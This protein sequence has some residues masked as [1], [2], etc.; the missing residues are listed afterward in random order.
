MSLYYRS[1]SVVTSVILTVMHPL[2]YAWGMLKRLSLLSFLMGILTLSLWFYLRGVNN[3]SES[4]ENNPPPAQPVAHKS[5]E[6]LLKEGSIF[7]MKPVINVLLIGLDTSQGR[8]SRG[9]LGSNT[10]VLILASVNTKTNRVLLTSVPRDLW[11]NGN[12]INALLSVYGWETLKDAFEKISGA[13]VDGYIKLDFDGLKWMVDSFGGVPVNVETDFTDSEFPNN[14]DSGAQTVTFN[15]GYE[16][17]DSERALIFARSRHGNNGEGSDLMR[18]KRQHLIL[19]GMVQAVKQPNSLFWPM[20]LPKFFDAVTT[21]METSLKLADVYYLWDF[22]KDRD[23]YQI[24]SFVIGSDY[25]YYPGMYPESEYH[26]WV[27]LPINNDFSKLQSDIKAKLEGTF[28]P[29][30]SAPM[31][32][33]N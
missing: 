1:Q 26:A 5:A 24:E 8:R 31:E 33:S 22:Y 30:N 14:A 20:D 18:A 19:Q 32:S 7:Y 21:H 25:L 17:L 15:K 3:K 4:V 27:F 2:L 11:V 23:L 29:V 10:D 28:I 6:E 13:T 9:Q 12:K 16:L